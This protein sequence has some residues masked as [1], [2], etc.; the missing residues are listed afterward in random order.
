M[1]CFPVLH[2]QMIQIF[3]NPSPTNNIKCVKF[4][5]DIH[6]AKQERFFDHIF[7]QQYDKFTFT[8]IKFTSGLNQNTE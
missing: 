8:D 4:P 2:L 7:P 6:E 5:K 1:V 3:F